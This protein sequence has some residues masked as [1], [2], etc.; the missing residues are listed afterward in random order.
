MNAVPQKLVSIEEFFAWL[1][2]QE[3]RF[4]LVNGHIRMMTG[5]AYRHNVVKNNVTVALTPAARKCG[6]NSTTSD[7]GVQTSE[8]SVRYPDVVVDCGP[9][10]PEAM[11]VSN[12]VILVEI[13]SPS[14]RGTD[15]AVKLFE[16]QRLQSVQVL[17]QIEP[18][19]VEV[20]VHRRAPDGSWQLELYEDMD[21]R[22]DLPPLATSLAIADIYFGLDVKPRPSL[23]LVGRAPG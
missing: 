16:Y 4:E 21:S 23:Q 11:T 8:R 1:V 17:V 2:H 7:T 3:G 13:S 5:A 14:T 6:C 22:I 10:A 12:P 15:L 19:L 18:D 20:A 9:Q